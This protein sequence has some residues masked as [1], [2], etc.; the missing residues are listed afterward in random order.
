MTKLG[1]PSLGVACCAALCWA[2]PS[3][4]VAA[5]LLFRTRRRGTATC[6]LA[7]TLLGL[8]LG[9]SNSAQAVTIPTVPVGD[10]GNANDP[11]TGNLY[12]GVAYDYRIG[13]TEV[14]VGQYVDFLK[15]GGRHRHLRV[16]TT[17]R[18]PRSIHLRGIAR[19]GTSGSYT[20]SRDRITSTS[21]SSM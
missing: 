13:T 4:A 14:T 1:H 15:C 2:I 12:G 5:L 7:S 21:P 19:S 18:W 20:Y 17:R 3:V 11:A 6:V 10:A 9:F 8:C 16:S